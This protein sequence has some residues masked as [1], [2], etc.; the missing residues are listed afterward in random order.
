MKALFSRG[1]IFS[2]LALL[3]L[4]PAAPAR[5]DGKDLTKKWAQ[6][7][8]KKEGKWGWLGKWL[9]VDR[10]AN[11]GFRSCPHF[12][13]VIKGV[14]EWPADYIKD[15]LQLNSSKSASQVCVEAWGCDL[16]DPS[17]E[18]VAAAHRPDGKK[19]LNDFFTGSEEQWRKG[20]FRGW[21]P[22]FIRLLGWYGDRELAPLIIKMAKQ[23]TGLN[24][25]YASISAATWILARWGKNDM[26]PEC[27][28]VFNSSVRKSEAR[29]TREDCINYFIEFGDKTV[30]EK[31]RRFQPNNLRTKLALAALGDKALTDKWKEAIK[32]HKKPTHAKRIEATTA[33]AALGD[34]KAK[35]AALAGLA[36]GKT[37]EMAGYARLLSVVR[38]T[39]YGAAAVKALKKGIKKVKLTDLRSAQALSFGAAYLLRNGD[40]SALPRVTEVLASGNKEFR[41]QMASCLAGD[42][43]NTPLVGPTSGLNGGVPVAAIAAILQ[44]AYEN[45]SDPGTRGEIGLA[46]VMLKAAG[47]K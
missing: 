10:C 1:I 30:I 9:I 46:W 14:K 19:I 21:R 37:E 26:L 16:L 15:S 7:L 39:K 20:T 11:K 28:A 44:K 2:G 23:K 41:K 29:Q 47:A 12:G 22:M 34:K 45:E 17:L 32:K 27:Q 3:M 36:S 38:K 18:M 42:A 40:K 25:D 6:A 24:S 31:I 8:K 5:A 4:L 35:K 33:L 43:K 13:T